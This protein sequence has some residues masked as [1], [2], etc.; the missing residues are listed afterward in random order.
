MKYD[1]D[2]LH[3]RSNT[4]SMKWQVG[5]NELPMWV[6]DM[7]F[8]TAPEIVRAIQER[9]AS[10][11]YGY[12]VV[13]QRWREAV[14]GWWAKR[15]HCALEPQWLGF[16]K[17]VI[18]SL[19]SAL[20]AF[21]EP[22]QKVLIQTPVYNGFFH[23]I[24]KN[25]RCVSTNPLIYDGRSY[26]MDFAD[27]DCKLADPETTLMFLCNPHNPAG[28]IWS[29][30]ELEQ[31]GALC[32]Q[33]GVTVIADEI[34]CDL[35]APGQ[36]YTPFISVSEEC[37]QISISCVSPTKTFNIAGIQTSAVI[38]P[39]EKLRTRMFEALS[40]DEADEPNVFA[41]DAAVA[42]YNEG[43]AWLAELRQY[44]WD[45]RRLAEQYIAEQIPQLTAV[46]GA[47]TYLLWIDCSRIADDSAEL[48]KFIRSK[49]GLFVTEGKVYGENGGTFL[50]MNLACPKARLEDGLRRLKQ[51]VE[52]DN[53]H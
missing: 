15:Y 19:A 40:A 46:A 10:G 43:E 3:N 13:P 1:F 16:S 17:G 39:N 9:A 35:T 26:Q 47:A 28:N 25:G 7:D 14:R 6:A 27:L 20:R 38:V 34:H 18:P 23:T 52:L 2:T 29:K 30:T 31:V 8:Q 41:V 36:L 11:I 37:R 5:E 48:R 33:H 32:R 50:R 45:N 44:L 24:E 22:G 21:T 4:D 53:N 12:G 49:T 51:A 42:A